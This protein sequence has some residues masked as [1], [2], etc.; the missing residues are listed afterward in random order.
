MNQMPIELMGIPAEIWKSI[1]DTILECDKVSDI[2][3]YGSRAKGSYHKFSDIDL[4]LIGEKIRHSDLLEIYNRIEELNLPYEIDLSIYSELDYA[5]L[6]NEID[7]F[8]KSLPD[9][10]LS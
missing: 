1:A 7:A 3:V 10:F 4:T 9:I 6:I 2:L 8:G 5:P